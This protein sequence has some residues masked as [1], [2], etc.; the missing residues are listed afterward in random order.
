[1]RSSSPQTAAAPANS[2]IAAGR[3]GT[4]RRG[5]RRPIER[6]LDLQEKD[7]ELGHDIPEI[8]ATHLAEFG[9]KITGNALTCFTDG[10]FG[11]QRS[12]TA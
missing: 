7:V 8:V 4:I 11:G 10:G 2:Q 12:G 1:V 5:G 9:E 6:C 3:S